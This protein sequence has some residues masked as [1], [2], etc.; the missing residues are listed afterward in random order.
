ML[1]GLTKAVVFDG[2]TWRT[3]TTPT[4]EAGAFTLTVAGVQ[5]LDELSL[6]VTVYFEAIRTR[7]GVASVKTIDGSEVIV[8]AK[9]QAVLRVPKPKNAERHQTER[10]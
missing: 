3:S 7:D 10:S 1:A 9:D 5:E 6:K 2:H 8:H 4:F